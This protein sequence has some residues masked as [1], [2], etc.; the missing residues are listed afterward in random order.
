MLDEDAILDPK[1]VRRNPVDGYAEP[2]KTPMD[3]DE[4]AISNDH[5]RLVFQRGRRTLQMRLNSPS[6]P[7]AMLRMV[8]DV[9]GRPI[10]FGRFILRRHASC[11]LIVPMGKL[12]FV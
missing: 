2:R 9:V 8:L 5:P 1:D 10:S 11:S 6:R 3:D 12:P 7:G 4:V